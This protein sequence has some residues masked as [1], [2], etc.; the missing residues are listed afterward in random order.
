MSEQV[1]T[2]QAGSTSFLLREQPSDGG[3]TPVLLLHGFPETATC[4]SALAPRL[5]TGRRVLAPDLPGLG[6]STYT[7]PYDVPSLVGELAALVELE[8]PGGRVD[9]VGHDW[10]G[11]LALALAGARPELVRRLVVANAPYRSVPARA[12]H[13]P[14]F[15]LPA[16]PELLF[17][18]GGRRVVDA[19]FA[20]AWRADTPLSAEALAEYRAAYTRPA[21]VSAMLGYYRAAARPRLARLVQRSA[22][23]VPVPQVRAER[24][25]VLWGAKDPVLPVSTGEAVVR[26]LGPECV[27]VTVPAAGHFVVEEAPDVVADVLLDFLADEQVAKPAAPPEKPDHAPVEP[28]PAVLEQPPL[29]A[30]AS[31]AP[32]S[33]AP[34]S[35]APAD[36]A[37][38]DKA[39]AS[40]APA[41][42]APASNAPAKKAPAKK[43]AASKR[44]P[45]SAG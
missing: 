36:K 5:A 30:P 3:G 1:R 12:L 17:R 38:A 2:V 9:V 4:W 42:N 26:D 40:K 21:V 25:L 22:P 31:K 11:S 20:I 14:F 18:L 27:M 32:A 23:P 19:A 8:V 44:V 6:G 16:A 28:P 34:A 29:T 39:P 7:G 10:G 15:A 35:K 41:S 24:A 45:P 13:I 37:P 43:K 33:K